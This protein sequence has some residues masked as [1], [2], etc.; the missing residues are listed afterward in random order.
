[1]LQQSI[2]RPSPS[3]ANKSMAIDPTKMLERTSEGVQSLTW[4]LYIA[5]AALSAATV[6]ADVSGTLLFIGAIVV[7]V[8]ASSRKTD[9][10]GSI[11]QSHLANVS[12]AM[13]VNLIAALVLMFITYATFFIGVIFTWP[14]YLIVLVYVGFRLI[15]GMMKLNDSQAY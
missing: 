2:S 8:L 4:V 5:S 12:H 15:R 10:A 7:I 6:M 1:M 11:H 14:A 9:A 13:W 3:W